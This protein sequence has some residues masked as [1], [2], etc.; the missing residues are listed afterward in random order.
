LWEHKKRRE[1]I[2]AWFNSLKKSD[3]VGKRFRGGE[4]HIGKGLQE[5]VLIVQEGNGEHSDS[6]LKGERIWKLQG[7]SRERKN[8]WEKVVIKTPGHKGSKEHN[9]WK[10][11][12]G[13]FPRTERTVERGKG[14]FAVEKKL[15]NR[16]SKKDVL[17]EVSNSH[18]SK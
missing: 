4:T 9:F 13:K 7:Y 5:D 15:Q 10:G 2:L 14:M 6:K 8:P 18:P 1:T 11:W 16:E 17:E 3:F 12:A